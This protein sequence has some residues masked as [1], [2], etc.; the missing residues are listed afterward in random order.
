MPKFTRALW[1]ELHAL[2]PQES[3]II[4]RFEANSTGPAFV[5]VAD[6]LR[7]RGYLDEAIV[8]LEE[9]LRKFPQYHSAR[10]ALARDYFHKGLLRDSAAALATVLA[11]GPDNLMAQRLRLRLALLF[12]ERDV[13]LETLKILKQLSPDDEFTRLTR[14]RLATDDWASARNAVVGEL[15]RQGVK[16]DP[17]ALATPLPGPRVMSPSDAMGSGGGSG[18]GAGAGVG[19]GGITGRNGMTAGRERVAQAASHVEALPPLPPDFSSG[20]PVRAVDGLRP[21]G[22]DPLRLETRTPFPGLDDTR[23]PEALSS[24]GSLASVRGDADRYMLLRGFRM[25]SPGSGRNEHGTRQEGESAPA[26]E[27]TTLAGIY[28][29]QG[30]HL[31][32]LEIY[33][34]LLAENPDDAD[35]DRRARRVREAARGQLASARAGATHPRAGSPEK[36]EKLRTLERLL[37]RLEALP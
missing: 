4:K 19:F 17:S 37:T 24:V 13:A 25:V 35:L 6:L 15:E 29:G 7:K 18:N 9:G 32:A 23:L 2:T 10:A 14:G 22:D 3:E 27:S 16:V 21:R 30:L 31:K 11:R 34:R 8:V 36:E 5:A 26:L 33:E 28:E 12:D 20:T 1:N